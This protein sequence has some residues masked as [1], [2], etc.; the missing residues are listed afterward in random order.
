MKAY[1]LIK[2]TNVLP[3]LEFE[4][5]DLEIDN[6]FHSKMYDDVEIG[7]SMAY[8]LFVDERFIGYFTLS[9]SKLYLELDSVE[10]SWPA[11]LVGQLGVQKEYQNKHYGSLMLSLA[12]K[13]AHQSRNIVGT[14]LLILKTFKKDIVEKFYKSNGFLISNEK[15]TYT[16]LYYDLNDWEIEEED[17]K[18][19]WNPDN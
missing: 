19:K 2:I 12:K 13:I 1:R 9:N 17:F 6:Y 8:F 10:K 14:R 4:S 15:K 18:N 7:N 11:T 16:E 3:G 5:G